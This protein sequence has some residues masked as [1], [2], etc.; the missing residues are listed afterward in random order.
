MQIRFMFVGVDAHIDP[1][2][3]RPFLRNVAANLPLPIGRTGSSAPTGCC[4]VLP[5]VRC[6]F[7][8]AFCRVDVGI[9]PYGHF[10]LSP[11]VVRFRLCILRGR[12]KPCPYVTVKDGILAAFSRMS[13]KSNKIFGFL[14]Q[15][16]RLQFAGRAFIMGQANARE[17]RAM[18]F[19][20][21]SKLKSMTAYLFLFE[22][23]VS[24]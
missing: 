13:Q 4:A 6:N 16:K 1:H 11:S 24:I 5:M 18:K 7:A 15:N 23:T 21:M 20:C 9:D 19:V 12:G 17:V 10:A 3:A 8:I 22:D 2:G 14:G